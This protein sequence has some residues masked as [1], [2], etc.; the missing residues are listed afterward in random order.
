MF[1]KFVGWKILWV[2]SYGCYSW[3]EG[4]RANIYEGK[5]RV[6]SGS[7]FI[8]LSYLYAVIMKTG[9]EL[10]CHNTTWMCCPYVYKLY[11]ELTQQL[12]E[13]FICV[14]NALA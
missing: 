4:I 1:V 13:I 3:C 6:M 10:Y 7:V 11:R 12:R 2:I 9:I 14:I 8:H 5:A